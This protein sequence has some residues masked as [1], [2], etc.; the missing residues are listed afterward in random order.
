MQIRPKANVDQV[1]CSRADG[2]ID[3]VATSN[4]I[5]IFNRAVCLSTS[6]GIAAAIAGPNEAIAMCST[7]RQLDADDFRSRAWRSVSPG[8]RE[9]PQSILCDPRVGDSSF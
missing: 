6:A 5:E 1:S 2:L 7:R 8:S 9:L 3:E 4:P